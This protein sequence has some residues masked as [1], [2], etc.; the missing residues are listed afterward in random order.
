MSDSP[1][2]GLC[3][4]LCA[5]VFQ[6]SFLLP[7][8]W[9]RQWAWEN[10]WLLFAAT[11]YLACPWLL[12]VATIPRLGEIYA[13]ATAGSLGAVAL[14]GTG[15]G[16]GAVT[17]GLGVDAMGLALGFAV[18]TMFDAQGVRRHSGRQAA[19]LNRILDDV[20]AH[21]GIQEAPLKEFL[22]HTPVEVYVGGAL[23][24]LVAFLFYSRG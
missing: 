5:G 10:Y 16:I 1:A 21:K 12:A 19:A 11:A 3:L 13:G 17:F 15:W 22:G 6:G 23:G 18:I 2:S 7:A 14:Y 4:V 8:K 24:V 9:M 20:Y